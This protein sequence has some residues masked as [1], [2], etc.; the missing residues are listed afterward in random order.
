MKPASSKTQRPAAARAAPKLIQSQVPD[1]EEE[2]DDPNDDDVEFINDES[3]EGESD[4]E[5][6]HEMSVSYT[7]L[8]LP[9]NREV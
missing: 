6:E 5:G 7:H 1:D 9:T 8:T 3:A 2:E 4:S